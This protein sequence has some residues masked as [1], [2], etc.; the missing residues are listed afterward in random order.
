MSP[1]LPNR[2]RHG[3]GGLQMVGESVPFNTVSSVSDEVSGRAEM[4]SRWL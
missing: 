2:W 3:D 4:T 1:S